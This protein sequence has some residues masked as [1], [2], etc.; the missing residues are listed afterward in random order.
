MNTLDI[1]ITHGLSVRQIPTEIIHSYAKSC[2]NSFQNNPMFHFVE[3]FHHKMNINLSE[4]QFEVR[5]KESKWGDDI[6]Y[7]DGSTYRIFSRYKSFPK[8]GGWWMVQKTNHTDS[9]VIWS[10]KDCFLAPTLEESV[11]LYMNSLNTTENNV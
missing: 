3:D 7:K 4:S 2:C 6:Y 5:K 1:I 8:N 10:K 11:S 9:Q